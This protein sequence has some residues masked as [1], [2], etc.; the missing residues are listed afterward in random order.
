M[1]SAFV[2]GSVSM[3]FPIFQSSAGTL[4]GPYAKSPFLL[5][6]NKDKVLKI[7]KQDICCKYKI[8]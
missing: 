5:T 8:M 6:T 4:H 7:W 2:L 3:I 1:I